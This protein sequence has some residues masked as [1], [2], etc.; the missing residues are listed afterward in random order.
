MTP[1]RKRAGRQIAA[2][3]A[4]WLAYDAIL[5]LKH[6]IDGTFSAF[7]SEASRSAPLIPASIGLLCGHWFLPMLFP[8]PPIVGGVVFSIGLAEML[9]LSFDRSPLWHQPCWP[10][11]PFV[12][13][14]MTAP[15]IWP[16]KGV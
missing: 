12:V 4:V 11:V 2:M 3:F 6:G 15:I 8:M 10:V 9:L 16:L 1:E 14:A 13:G 7:V 5:L